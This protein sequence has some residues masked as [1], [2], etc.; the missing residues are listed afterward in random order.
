MP[1]NFNFITAFPQV[2]DS[3]FKEGVVGG[4][5]KKNLWSYQ[6]IDLRKF[7]NGVHHSIDDRPYSGSDGMLITAPVLEK[8]LAAVGVLLGNTQNQNS[9]H[10]LIYLSPQGKVFNQKMA[11]QW[12]KQTTHY[13]LICGR[14][15]GIDQRVLTAY[16]AIEEISIG[17]YIISGG[18]LAAC[19]LTDTLVR[20]IPNTLGHH[21]SHINDSFSGP[22]GLLEPPL[23][24][25]PA[26]W[27]THSVPPIL[28]SGDHKR[29]AHA[30]EM[31]SYWVTVKKRPEVLLA[32]NLPPSFIKMAEQFY[33]Q[34]S[35]EDKK[36][37][38]I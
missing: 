19:V 27:N 22:L 8:S 30:Q 34:L 16:P 6:L 5:L 20:L 17:D 35:E 2:I 28:L 10:K 38:G 23:F 31:L 14:Y 25:R 37:F 26:V 11:L 21:E 15:G 13:T 4:A 24:T 1:L 7:G 18:E 36:S 32:L 29:V 9:G 33:N 3:Y 12:H